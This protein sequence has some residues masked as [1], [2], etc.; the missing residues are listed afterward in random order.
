MLANGASA[1]SIGTSTVC[2]TSRGRPAPTAIPTLTSTGTAIVARAVLQQSARPA[3]VR[4]VPR[5]G[6][7]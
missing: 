4:A 6:T 3:F 1:S 2:S 5:Q 7:E